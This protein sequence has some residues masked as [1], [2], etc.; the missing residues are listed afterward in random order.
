MLAARFPSSTTAIRQ[1]WPRRVRAPHLGQYLR[2]SDIS[3]SL[4]ARVFTQVR[5]RARARVMGFY[6]GGIVPT[7][8][9]E[10]PLSAHAPPPSEGDHARVFGR[11]RARARIDPKTG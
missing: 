1:G 10:L 2:R 9:P 3:G 5:G 11:A 6:S 7:A 4:N 8:G